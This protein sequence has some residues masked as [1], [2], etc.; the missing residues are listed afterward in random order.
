MSCEILASWKKWYQIII[1]F[2]TDGESGTED[3][4]LQSCGAEEPQ[5]IPCEPHGEHLPS[6]CPAVDP[7]QAPHRTCHGTHY[8][9]ENQERVS[10]PIV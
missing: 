9:Q 3:R 5:L 6:P 2:L 1:V 7:G 10:E 4:A 8:S